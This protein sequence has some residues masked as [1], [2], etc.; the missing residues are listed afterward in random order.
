MPE[1]PGFTNYDYMIFRQTGFPD[2]EK[3]DKL[4]HDLIEPLIG[5]LRETD[6]DT[7]PELIAETFRRTIGDRSDPERALINL[8]RLAEVSFRSTFLHDLF[9]YPVLMDTAVKICSDSQYLADILVRH[10]PWFRWITASDILNHPKNS[11]R[12]SSELTMQLQAYERFPSQLNAMRRFQRRE[13]LRIGARDL[14]GEATFEQTVE[15]LSDLADAVASLLFDLISR[16]LELKHG[17]C[18]KTQCTVIG[19]GKL[20]G[21]ELN[22]SS[23]I[24]VMFV[25]D[26]DEQFVTSAGKSMHSVE[27]YYELADRWVRSMTEHSGEGRLYR[28][29]V[30]LRPDG[31]A[32]PLVRSLAGY[33]TYYET[34]GELWERQMLIKARPIA[35]A[36]GFGDEFVRRISP[37]VYPVTLFDPPRQIIS[38]MKSRIERQSPDPMNIKQMRGGIRDIE[39][40]TQALQLINGGRLPSVR[41][42]A[43]LHG[44]RLLVSEGLLSEPEARTL[45]DAY[46]FF[47]TVEHRLQMEHNTQTHTIPPG[48]RER[49][50]LAR[51]LGFG[52][53]EAFVRQLEEHLHGVRAIFDTVF[54]AEADKTDLE[55]FFSQGGQDSDEHLASFGFQDVRRA[56]EILRQIAV[57][58]TAA[59]IEG[60]DRQT[61]ERFRATG[62]MILADIKNTISPDRALKNVLLLVQSAAHA[63]SLYESLGSGG[64]RKMLLRVCGFS[65]AMTLKL[66]RRPEYLE[67]LL[68][69]TQALLEGEDENQHPSDGE[70][71]ELIAHIRFLN[72]KITLDEIYRILTNLA[73]ETL[74]SVWRSALDAFGVQT[75]AI[76][77][78]MLGKFSGDELG[79]GGDI[80]VLFIYDERTVTDPVHAEKAVREFIRLAAR[81]ETN[82]LSYEVDARLR[83]EGQSAPLVV[84]FEAYREYLHRR[85]SLWERQS[86]IRASL[87]EHKS[88]F[89]NEVLSYVRRYVYESTLPEAWIRDIL[90]MRLRSE[91]RSR[92]RRSRTVDIKTGA[93]GIMDI[94]FLVQAYQLK[95]GRIQ[96]DLRDI[97]TL[98]IL[99][100]FGKLALLHPDEVDMMRLAYYGYR[101]VEYFNAMF[102]GEPSKLLPT[103]PSQLSALRKFMELEDDPVEYITRLQ[104]GMR[105]LFL[106]AMERLENT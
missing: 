16:E 24:D 74:M 98:R 66:S 54:S 90:Q 84:S 9:A 55:I 58:I 49:E 37:F 80:D 93:G 46:V 97:S 42:P 20:G 47:R 38:R 6:P 56:G 25:M 59:G 70:F 27:F 12:L 71:Q 5:T 14:L 8:H 76:T 53:A 73:R 83:P 62:A 21:R 85:A 22:Y 64:I 101:L 39:F 105:D 72:G 100:T 63:G 2:S 91:S 1:L 41:T 40:I 78:V 19:L 102:I 30:R 96:H 65:D 34:R 50:V 43:T 31:D 88:E 4:L 32:G 75:D 81:G 7:E 89:Q 51:S 103:D 60:N 82:G 29:D 17:G 61:R 10:P 79:P 11:V 36:R 33:L 106:R 48:L 77:I 68:T 3:A 94:E 35:G 44:Q 95:F 52:S 57:G 45:S 86:L 67:F 104:S 13:I 28:V 23:D 26:D 18:P 87:L 15:E 99:D 92:I 69:R